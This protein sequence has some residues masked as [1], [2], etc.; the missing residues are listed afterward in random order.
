MLAIFDLDGT[1]LPLPSAEVRFAASLAGSGLIG[2][3]QLAGYLAFAVSQWPHYR[4]RT[5]KRNKA[6]LNRLAV[7]DIESRADAFVRRVLLPRLRPALLAHLRRHQH[8]GDPVLLLTGAPDFLARP[9]CRELGIAHCIATR[10]TIHDGRFAAGA[11]R[12]QPLGRDKR[13]LA[14]AFCSRNGLSLQEACA[15]CDSAHDLPLLEV[16]GRVVAV[17]PD[18]GLARR[19]AQRGWRILCS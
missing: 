13:T 6:Y 17:Y 16:V 8:A 9:L 3:R 14:E 18:A 19:A 12:V 1:L 11:P 2:P 7:T 10:C 15:Y 4:G 5:W